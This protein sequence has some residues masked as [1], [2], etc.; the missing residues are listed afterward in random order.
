MEQDEQQGEATAGNLPPGNSTEDE[1]LPGSTCSL[2]QKDVWHAEDMFKPSVHHGSTAAFFRDL[3]N[4]LLVWDPFIKAEVEV[5]ARRVLGLSWSELEKT[6]FSFCKSVCPRRI[7]PPHITKPL[8]EKV[9]RQY[10]NQLDAK[11]NKPLF[12]DSCH[13][14][15][16][17]LLRLLD[18]GRIA[19]PPH[20]VL[21]HKSYIDKQGFQRYW[22]SRGTNRVEGGPHG[23]VY[24]KFSPLQG[25]VLLPSRSL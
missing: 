25:E 4:A 5:R 8:V 1:W 18:E 24:R 3:N 16:R 20:V 19:D 17:S 22:C 7:R 23:D 14:A 13:E 21:F 12:N 9:L 6:R 2:H 11:T 10:A 15:G